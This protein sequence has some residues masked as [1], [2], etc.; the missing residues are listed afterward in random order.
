MT[1][2]T[3]ADDLRARFDGDNEPMKEAIYSG[4][5]SICGDTNYPLSMGGS[6]ICPSCDCGDY[7]IT[8]VQRQNK[9]IVE[10]TKQVNDWRELW[11]KEN[12]QRV[13]FQV[14]VESLR[15]RLAKAEGERD[16]M[17]RH[18]GR[19]CTAA[20][21]PAVRFG[22]GKS[23]EEATTDFIVERLKDYIPALNRAMHSDGE[24]DDLR[25]RLLA[26]ETAAAQMHGNSDGYQGLLAEAQLG[27]RAIE[28]I[29]NSTYWHY[30]K[31]RSFQ[32]RYC[33]SIDVNAP[34]KIIHLSSCLR[35]LVMDFAAATAPQGGR[36]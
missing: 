13:E 28:W 27:R 10:L 17:Y 25:T 15:E 20:G 24:L 23:I 21:N 29:R 36:E 35:K 19:I 11:T 2:P 26:A 18:F 7:G 9:R 22:N 6:S 30:S 34:S 4:P 5:C 14:E 31:N 33:K 3:D 8:K 16:E 32:C 12:V 1:Q